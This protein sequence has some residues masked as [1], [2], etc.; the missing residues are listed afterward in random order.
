M[1]P[2]IFLVEN[3]LLLIVIQMDHKINR[4]IKVCQMHMKHETCEN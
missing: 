3:H 1:E 2:V 4:M